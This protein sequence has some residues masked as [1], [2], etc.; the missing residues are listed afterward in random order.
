MIFI[1]F[2]CHTHW[3]YII[4][5][6]IELLAFL[7]FYHYSVSL[8]LSRIAFCFQVYFVQYKHIYTDF[9]CVLSG[10]DKLY[11]PFSLMFYLVYLSC[12]FTSHKMYITKFC[13][14]IYHVFFAVVSLICL[15]WF[16]FSPLLKWQLYT[17]SFNSFFRNCDIHF[18]INII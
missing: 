16:H 7:S 11:K 5:E 8:S 6:I 4:K 2:W 9:T 17:V 10:N 15:D 18:L 13:P 3:D 14:F 12:A 1:H